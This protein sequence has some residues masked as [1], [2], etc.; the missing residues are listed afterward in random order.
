[1]HKNSLEYVLV[2]PIKMFF[3]LK[4][5]PI[6]RWAS[7]GLYVPKWSRGQR[8]WKYTKARRMQTGGKHSFLYNFHVQ[9]VFSPVPYV[10]GSYI[11]QQLM[12]FFLYAFF[13]FTISNMIVNPKATCS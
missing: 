2:S 7:E 8:Q 1:M 12:R 9:M 5:G 3:T 13:N 10:S 4:D 11:T 6:E